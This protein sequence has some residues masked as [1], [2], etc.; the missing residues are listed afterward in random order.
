MSACNDEID[1]IVNVC[2]KDDIVSI[3]RDLTHAFL[4]PYLRS[5]FGLEEFAHGRTP[6]LNPKP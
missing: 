1:E 5:T 2:C 4:I 3:F 6:T